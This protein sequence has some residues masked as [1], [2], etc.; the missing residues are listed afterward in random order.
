[1]R[2]PKEESRILYA[3]TCNNSL[4]F[5]V[6]RLDFME[7]FSFICSVDA[8]FFSIINEISCLKTFEEIR[9]FITDS[10]ALGQILGSL[11]IY[12]ISK[13]LSQELLLKHAQSLRRICRFTDNICIH[14]QYGMDESCLEIIK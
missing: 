9:Y 4:I 2:R 14:K 3:L 5:V 12:S 8:D 13:S 7:D 10:T 1:L 6:Y 11:G